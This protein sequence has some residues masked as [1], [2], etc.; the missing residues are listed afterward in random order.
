MSLLSIDTRPALGASSP[1]ITLKSVVLP[2]PLGPMR[3][4]MRPAG[5][6]NDTLS[7]ARLPPNRTTTPSTSSW[8]M[9]L[10]VAHAERGVHRAHVGIGEGPGDPEPLERDFGL[11][12]LLGGRRRH[13]R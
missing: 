5:A 12:V 6:L 1:V 11:D 8:A 7:T 10:H 3:P 2:A 13:P 9:Q 4:V